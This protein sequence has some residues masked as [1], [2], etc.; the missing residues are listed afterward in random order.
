MSSIGW[1]SVRQPETLTQKARQ[2]FS[3]K[4]T[5]KA[6]LQTV[7][8]PVSLGYTLS[9][10]LIFGSFVGYL[11]SAQQILQQL[12]KLGDQFSIVFGGLALAIGIS[13]YINSRLLKQFSMRQ[14]VL[15]PLMLLA[16]VSLAFYGYTLMRFEQPALIIL[17]A[18]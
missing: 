11:S 18:Y 15:F 6:I 5:G 17:L 8:N 9:S 13:S 16:M 4:K 3:F 1:L 7:K 14:L 10:G 12:Y 2:T